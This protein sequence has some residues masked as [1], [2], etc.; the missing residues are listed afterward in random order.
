MILIRLN[1]P[2][3]ME[4]LHEQAD[5]RPRRAD[6]LGQFFMGNL[7]LDTNAARIF[8][9]HGAG[10]LQQRLAQP[11]LA[12]DRD[13]IGDDLLLVGYAHRQVAHEP[14]IQRVVA[15]TGKEL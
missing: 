14:L 9:A 7:E 12:I 5:P 2:K 10:Q 15:Q 1:Q 13:E 4:P 8:L 11:L 6:H 3:V